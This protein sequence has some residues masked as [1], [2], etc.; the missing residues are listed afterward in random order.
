MLDPVTNTTLLILIVIVLV[1]VLLIHAFIF[2][3]ILILLHQKTNIPLWTLL[4]IIMICAILAVNMT[5]EVSRVA[6]SMGETM[7][8]SG[9][10]TVVALLLAL[11][12]IKV[13]KEKILR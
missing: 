11:I 6:L 1:A 5:A 13:L 10:A 8:Y 7:V 9:I 2:G 4:P 3:F 12:G